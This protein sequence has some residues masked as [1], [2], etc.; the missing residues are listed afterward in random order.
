MIS[1]NVSIKKKI[2][3]LAVHMEDGKTQ[4]SKTQMWFLRLW[5]GTGKIIDLFT[6]DI[7]NLWQKLFHPFLR[8][9]KSEF[10]A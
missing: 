5:R 8:A 2:T 7:L 1:K 4:I 3:I 6:K 10:I 9:V